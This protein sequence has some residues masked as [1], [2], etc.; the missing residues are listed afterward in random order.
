MHVT[1]TG[2]SK[3]QAKTWDLIQ[4]LSSDSEK[5]KSAEK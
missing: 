1:K 4:I 2:K 3:M 5:I